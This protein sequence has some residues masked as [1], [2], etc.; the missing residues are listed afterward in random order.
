MKALCMKER[1]LT[2]ATMDETMNMIIHE[3]DKP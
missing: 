3:I 2:R 1:P